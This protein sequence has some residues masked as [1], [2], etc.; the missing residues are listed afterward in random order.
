M[1]RHTICCADTKLLL[2]ARFCMT[3]KCHWLSCDLERKPC[4]PASGGCLPPL[5]HFLSGVCS[6]IAFATLQKAAQ[7]HASWRAEAAEAMTSGRLLR[8]RWM[9]SQQDPESSRLRGIPLEELEQVI[10]YALA[11]PQEMYPG[12][13]PPLASEEGLEVTQPDDAEAASS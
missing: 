5:V 13:G 9:R 11:N 6:E 8:T 1:V 10:Q 4:L 3:C 2:H 7:E 12:Q